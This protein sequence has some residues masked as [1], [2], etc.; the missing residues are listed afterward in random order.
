[1]GVL[2]DTELTT[3]QVLNTLISTIGAIVLSYIGYLQYKSRLA[4]VETKQAM[5]QTKE[6]VT[7]NTEAVVDTK[8]AVVRS[9]DVALKTAKIAAGHTDEV[10][11]ALKTN[12]EEVKQE[13]QQSRAETSDRLDVIHGLVNSQMTAEKEKSLKA[14]RGEIVSTEAQLE[15][16]R[17]VASMP[18]GKP[19]H[20][21]VSLES[22]LQTLKSEEA[23]LAAEVVERTRQANIISQQAEAKK[24][25]ED[26]T[27]ANTEA[28][29][30][31]TE[32]LSKQQEK[33]G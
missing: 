2:A 13:L 7:A 21:S 1:M 4:Q 3:L 10:K 20:A 17:I 8:D 6:A 25:G 18:G 28:T 9:T 30:A 23:N 19:M 24:A 27:A 32:A 11:I 31:N 26:V 16:M 29:V 5:I 12:Q 22:R 14:L 15:L 33:A